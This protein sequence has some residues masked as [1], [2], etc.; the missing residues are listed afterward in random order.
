MSRFQPSNLGNLDYSTQQM[1]TTYRVG[2][3]VGDAYGMIPG[4]SDAIGGAVSGILAPVTAIAGMVHE[5]KQ[6]KN[7]R[8]HD[9]T[10]AKQT[11]KTMDKQ[12]ELAMA[13]AELAAVEAEVAREQSAGTIALASW[14]GGS[15]M[16]IGLLGAGVYAVGQKKAQRRSK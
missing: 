4:V 12:A 6:L 3:D 7:M 5:G 8:E 10:M 13:Q 1:L 14:V 9:V 2:M 16:L 15:I 11:R